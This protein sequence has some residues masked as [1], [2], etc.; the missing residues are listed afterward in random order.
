MDEENVLEWMASSGDFFKG[1]TSVQQSHT[2]RQQVACPEVSL[3]RPAATGAT[4]DPQQERASGNCSRRQRGCCSTL[5]RIV[6]H[7]SNPLRK[8]H[9]GRTQRSSSVETSSGSGHN[10]SVVRK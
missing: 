10:V 6:I 9:T 3:Q 7:C 1:G 8:V 4:Q 5:F 2:G